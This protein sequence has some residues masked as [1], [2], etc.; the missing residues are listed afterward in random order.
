MVGSRAVI[1]TS[2]GDDGFDFA[3]RLFIRGREDFACGS[4]QTGL[5]PYWKE[6]LGKSRLTSIQP[7]RR[8]SE[9]ESEPLE[10]GVKITSSAKILVEGRMILE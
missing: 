10:N 1:A 5:A 2:R 6:K 8:V 9:I 7:H 4:V 3:Y